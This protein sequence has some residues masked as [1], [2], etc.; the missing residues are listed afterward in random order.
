M[1][2]LLLK[3]SV[4]INRLQAQWEAENLLT[5]FVSSLFPRVRCSEGGNGGGKI[6]TSNILMKLQKE[7]KRKSIRLNIVSGYLN[8]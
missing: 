2:K 8:L 3:I 1:C 5:I 7:R 6:R 4:L